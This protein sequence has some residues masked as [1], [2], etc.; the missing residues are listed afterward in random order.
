MSGPGTLAAVLA[1]RMPY[2]VAPDVDPNMACAGI[3]WPVAC[4]GACVHSWSGGQL[5]PLVTRY[6][7]FSRAVCGNNFHLGII[8]RDPP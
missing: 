6:E 2:V 4:L 1:T 7:Y 3:S 8:C 5:V